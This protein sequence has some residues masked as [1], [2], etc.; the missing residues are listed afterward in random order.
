[1]KIFLYQLM[2]MKTLMKGGVIFPLV[3]SCGILFFTSCKKNDDDPSQVTVTSVKS[4]GV[5]LAG[6][7]SATKISATSNL[8]VTF[9]KAV[10]AVTAADFTLTPAIPIVVSGSG[11][12]ITIDPTGDLLAGT[13]YTLAIKNSVKATDGGTFTAQSITFKTDGL[14]NVTP[15]QSARQIA[16]FGFNNIVNSSVG[17][18]SVE[19]VSSSYTTDR[20]GYANS[21]VSFDGMKDIIEVANGSALFPGPNSTLSFWIW[22]DTTTNPIHNLFAMG[23]NGSYGSV[24]EID[25]KANWFKNGASFTNS[26]NAQLGEDLFFNG[27]GKFG[28]TGWQGHSFNTDLSAT[29]GVK[30]NI[31]M[32]WAQ[33]VYTYDAASKLRTMYLNGIKMMQSDFNKWPDGDVKRN[34]T[35]QKVF[36]TPSPNYSNVF[37]FGFIT[38]RSA[39]IFDMEPWGNYDITTSNHFKGKLDDVRFFDV[40]LT[41][42]EITKL[43]NDEK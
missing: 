4:N 35:G 10:N 8:V 34:V 37:A 17:T 15:P 24:V 36:T 31:A 32:K 14:T 41:A 6:A 3:L 1:M 27:D 19:N 5:E 13:S 29:G 11:T 9:N 42:T 12:T 26:S 21:A 30:G 39:T 38:D 18:W 23:I 43:Y 16:Y 25:A 28:N 2:I 33:I 22:T 7:T 40:A 20:G